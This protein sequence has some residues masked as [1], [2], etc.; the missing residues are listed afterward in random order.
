MRLIKKRFLEMPLVKLS[1]GAKFIVSL[2]VFTLYKNCLA[3]CYSLNYP[4]LS[5][6]E[7]EIFDGRN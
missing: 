5:Q 1:K 2:L 7:T 3:S 6:I 4:V